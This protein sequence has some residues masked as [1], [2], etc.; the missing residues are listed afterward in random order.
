MRR[1][2]GNYGLAWVLPALFMVSWV[3][4]T[5]TGWREFQSE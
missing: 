2:L 5:W 1:P 3:L 4:Q